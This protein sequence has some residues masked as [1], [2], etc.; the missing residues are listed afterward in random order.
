MRHDLLA[1][2]RRPCPRHPRP[3][4][5]LLDLLARPGDVHLP[6]HG[7]RIRPGLGPADEAERQGPR[8]RAG[9]MNRRRLTRLPDGSLWSEDAYR[10]LL[11]SWERSRP[12]R[13]VVRRL[14]ESM[15]ELQIE[16][17]R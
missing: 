17:R 7:Q 1:L 8:P 3:P 11:A 5:G 13:T 16:G 10:A 15:P 6:A 14:S 9:G 4:R 2:W 12:P